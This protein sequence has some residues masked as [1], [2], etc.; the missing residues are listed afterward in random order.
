MTIRHFDFSSFSF[1]KIII[2]III[3]TFVQR[4]DVVTPGALGPGSV[5]L[6]RGKRE[7]PGEEER[8]QPRV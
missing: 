5:P 1:Q 3:N 7:S 2:I 8:L 4:H 6:R